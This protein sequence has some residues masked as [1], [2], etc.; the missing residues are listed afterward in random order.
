MFNL[1]QAVF[2]SVYISDV[3]KEKLGEW[4]SLRDKECLARN[5]FGLSQK[6]LVIKK[7]SNEINNNLK[8]NDIWN[9]DK[10]RIRADKLKY[11]LMENDE[12]IKYNLIDLF[13]RSI[14]EIIKMKNTNKYI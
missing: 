7:K 9:L 1:I 4:I 14:E 13:E 10:I 3:V 12:V 8:I 5:K 2:S 6:V 11:D